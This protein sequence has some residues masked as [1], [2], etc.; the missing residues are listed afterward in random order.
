MQRLDSSAAGSERVDH[1]RDEGYVLLG[2]LREAHG[3]EVRA[4]AWSILDEDIMQEV[5]RTFGD[6]DGAAFLGARAGE[7]HTQA[8]TETDPRCKGKR[9]LFEH[10]PVYGLNACLATRSRHVLDSPL[11]PLPS[12]RASPFF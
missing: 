11:S 2:H 10:G 6:R 4:L 3:N 1:G 9:R 7:L 5:V 12:A 8:D